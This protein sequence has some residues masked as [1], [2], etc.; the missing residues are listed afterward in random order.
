MYK[1]IQNYSMTQEDTTKKYKS[2]I[3]LGLMIGG[4]VI[5][6]VLI[7]YAAMSYF[8]VASV[9]EGKLDD[10]KGISYSYILSENTITLEQETGYTPSISKA[11]ISL[12]GN[13]I[14]IKDF[15]QT[16]NT[17]TSS[18]YGK[19]PHEIHIWFDDGNDITYYITVV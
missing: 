2:P 4:I 3:L 9:K 5:A 11:T 16:G 14:S 19:V 12:P 8:N 15:T 6:V 18:M 7:G 13:V 17:F 1:Q 10:Y